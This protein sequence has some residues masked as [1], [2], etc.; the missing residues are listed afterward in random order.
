MLLS[1]NDVAHLFSEM[2]G[3]TVEMEFYT[4]TDQADE[5]QP[6][7]LFVPLGE[8]SR[9]LSRAIAN[10][11]V[12]AIWTK[13]EQLPRY[14]P[15]HFPVFFADDPLEAVI[16]IIQ[17]YNEKLNGETDCIMEMT[18]FKISNKKLLNKNHKTYDIAVMLKQLSEK[19]DHNREG[20]G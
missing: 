10:G 3:V 4:V 19:Q 9:E 8:E 14:T 5:I 6:R 15:N 2:Q 13:G 12:A 20:R 7:G 1:F 11:A 17:H 18:N 16:R